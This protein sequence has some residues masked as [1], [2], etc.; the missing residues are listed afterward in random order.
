[1]ELKDATRGMRVRAAEKIFDMMPDTPA[2][3]KDTPGIV[4]GVYGGA[5]PYPMHLPP[6]VVKF[7]GRDRQMM[8]FPK[9]ITFEN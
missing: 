9:E 1:M 5:S 8:C 6:V 3:E 7:D 4:E 2:V